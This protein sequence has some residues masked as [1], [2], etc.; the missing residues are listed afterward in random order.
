MPGV[1]ILQCGVAKPRP[2]TADPSAEQ[3]QQITELL[4]QVPQLI[5]AIKG[6]TDEE[7]VALGAFANDRDCASRF[8]RATK[9]DLAAAVTRLSDTLK[10]RREYRPDL[11]SADEIEP[12]A[13][14]GKQFLSGF[15]KQGRPLLFL[16]PRL[17]NTKT[18]DRQIRYSVYMLEKAIKVMPAGVERIDVVIDYE[19]LNMFNAV[20]MSVS[21]KYLNILSSHYP[22]RL[23]VGIVVNPSWY[24]SVFFKLLSPFMDPVTKAK[25][26]F[27][28]VDRSGKTSNTES[29]VQK[30]DTTEGTGGWADILEIADADQ[31]PVEF[32]GKYDFVYDH[33]VYWEKLSQI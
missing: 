25:L 1:P 24:L 28:K 30:E 11:I 2:S 29:S 7:A 6:L 31:L 8:L 27:C 19:N 26:Y 5:N 21:L 16:V 9:W 13:V 17:E 12:E 18:Y 15:D 20:P 10:W 32:G 3:Q 22:E 23:G 14:T 4:S 33:K